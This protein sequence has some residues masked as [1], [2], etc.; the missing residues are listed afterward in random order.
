MFQSC[1]GLT[2]LDLSTWDTGNVTNMA[3]MFFGC[4][5]L[6]TIYVGEGWSVPESNE[7]MFAV[8][9]SLVGCMGTVFDPDHINGDYARID[10]GTDNPGYLTGLFSITLPDDIEHGTLE[11]TQGDKVLVNGD[12]VVTGST[13]TLT[14][15]PDPRYELQ[16]LTVTIAGND[17]DDEPGDA[18]RRLRGGSI[19]LTPGDEPNTFTFE[20]PAAAVEVN[21]V[22]FKNVPTDINGVIDD[23]RFPHDGRRYNLL[24]Q[25]VGPDYKGVVI[26]NGK[27]IWI[28]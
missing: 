10:G 14:V 2:T 6:T 23:P 25:P 15:T 4:S 26:Q 24:G 12:M 19:D 27:K 13:V 11:A 21:A 7:H 3:A 1:T 18:P 17:D 28:K 9:T 16:S 5:N 8:C 20:M 22:F